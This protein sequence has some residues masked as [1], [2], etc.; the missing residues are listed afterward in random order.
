MIL[1]LNTNFISFTEL[2]VCIYQFSG[3]WL[4][5]FLKYPLFSAFPIEKLKLEKK[6][7]LEGYL[8]FLGMAAILVMWPSSC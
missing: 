1:A 8:P 5:Q 3:H 4:Q 6:K 7:M 2:V